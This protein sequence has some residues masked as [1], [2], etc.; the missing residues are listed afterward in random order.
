MEMP[1]I[2]NSLVSQ[3]LTKSYWR[4]AELFATMLPGIA[5]LGVSKLA[6]SEQ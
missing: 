4:S 1:V 3:G 5:F 6:G 2:G